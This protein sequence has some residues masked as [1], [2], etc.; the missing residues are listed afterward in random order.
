MCDISS[1][2]PLISVPRYFLPRCNNLCPA[3]LSSFPRVWFQCSNSSFA[4]LLVSISFL[5]LT[6]LKQDPATV[7]RR[8]EFLHAFGI[9]WFADLLAS[10]GICPRFLGI[11]SFGPPSPGLTSVRLRRPVELFRSP[12]SPAFSSGCRISFFGLVHGAVRAIAVE[13]CSHHFPGDINLHLS[14]PEC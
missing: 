14:V 7:L 1:H 9:L 4:R 5:N 6:R 11:G 2:L 3:L 8:L 13:V 10:V 12:P